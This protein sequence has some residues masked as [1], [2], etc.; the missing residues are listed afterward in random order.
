VSEG[1]PV[2]S[3]EARARVQAIVTA[4]RA[5]AYEEAAAEYLELIGL[6]DGAVQFG[7]VLIAYVDAMLDLLGQALGEEPEAL[8]ARMCRNVLRADAE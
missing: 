7:A 8:W 5:E 1:R 4:F 3:V 2:T 6:E